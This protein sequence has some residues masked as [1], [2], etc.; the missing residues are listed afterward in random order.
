MKKQAIDPLIPEIGTPSSKRPRTTEEVH[1]EQNRGPS[2]P[3]SMTLAD[4]DLLDC[5]ICFEP[6]SSPVYQCE[7]GHTACGSCCTT[8]LKNKCSNCCLPIGTI[9]CRAIEKVVVSVRVTCQYM[10]YG[11]AEMFSYSKKVAHEKACNYVPLSCP[12]IGCDFVGISKCLYDH[13]PWKHKDFSRQF[14]FNTQVFI[15]VSST[16][17]HV[18]LREGRKGV[19]FI[20]NRCNETIGSCFNV[21]CLAPPASENRYSYELTASENR[22]SV[23]VKTSVVEMMPKWTAQPPAKMS[24]IVP[25]NFISTTQVISLGV[26]IRKKRPAFSLE[27]LLG[28]FHK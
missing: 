5:P 28:S 21:V 20:L 9:R 8:I 2:G 10:P 15:G 12:C 25:S 1:E 22:Y 16:D 24:L 11:C 26:I 23:N 27:D 19:L 17:N 6:L 7:N 18:I 4:P 14:Y 13:F 3:L